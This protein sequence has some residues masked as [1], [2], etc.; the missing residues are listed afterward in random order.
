MNPGQPSSIVE[1]EPASAPT[2]LFAVTLA[3][4]AAP[5]LE[6]DRLFDLEPGFGDRLA[7]LA[8]EALRERSRVV[9][10]RYARGVWDPAEA[11]AGRHPAFALL[12]VDG[13][14]LREL[15]DAGGRSSEP[16]GPGD[17]ICRQRVLEE[18]AS[19]QWRALVA[20][21]VARLDAALISRLAAAAP[22]LDLL[23]QRAAERGR[24]LGALALSRALRRTDARLMLMLTVLATRWGRIRSDGIRL[25]LPASH[26]QLANLIGTRRQAVS[27]A[28][29]QLRA[30]G[31]LANL[32]GGDWLLPLPERVVCVPLSSSTRPA[33]PAAPRASGRV[34]LL[35]LDGGVVARVPRGGRAVADTQLR[36]QTIALRRGRWLPGAGTDARIDWLGLLVV[37]G[38]LARETRHEDHAAL[39]I[40]G[41]GD[42]L[43]PWDDAIDE[44]LG[45]V[46]WRALVP[47]RLAL[48]DDEFVRRAAL[49]PAV[50]A[51]LLARPGRRANWF[52]ARLLTNAHTAVDTR[53]MRLLAR[54]A[55]R[56][57]SSPSGTVPVALTHGQV[58]KLVGA[59]RPS[60]SQ[61][62]GRLRAQGLLSELPDG[63]WH[64]VA[65]ALSDTAPSPAPSRPGV[66][67]LADHSV[68]SAFL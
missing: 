41:P 42:L 28:L 26:E 11:W 17:L 15:T 52:N 57:A 22:T 23:A 40:L 58:A 8:M 55:T 2:G 39:E 20:G 14:L 37:E 31:Q 45:D 27:T 46:C 24:L 6:I 62:F 16:F 18:G 29:S 4:L 51:E 32:P 64:I 54:L 66:A 44:F 21:R 19:E 67:A 5:G 53:I 68:S 12:V 7:M 50:I 63:R 56:W 48:L 43:R 38:F 49:W 10:R 36:I 1:H 13:I 25:T 59:Q 61:A 9:V 47:T 3:L 65:A 33:A 30:S 60:V 35:A 34:S